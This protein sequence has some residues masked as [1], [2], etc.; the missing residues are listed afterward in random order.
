[1]L[2]LD[3]VTR[4]RV[5]AVILWFQ[6]RQKQ[7]EIDQLQYELGAATRRYQAEVASL[8]QRVAEM[9]LHLVESRKEADEYYK[10]TL[11]RNMENMALGNEVEY[12]GNIDNT[13]CVA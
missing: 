7:V 13:P 6:P 5:N 9:D 4:R 10:G 1:M 2:L 8:R 11:E 3:S 12:S